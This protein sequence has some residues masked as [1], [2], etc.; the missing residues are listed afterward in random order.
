MRSTRSVLALKYT[1]VSVMGGVRKAVGGF[2]RYV[3]HRDQHQEP[4]R[5]GGLD[6]RPVQGGPDQASS[7]DHGRRAFAGDY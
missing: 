2:L 5:D 4:E 3:Q 7:E 1:P 6:A